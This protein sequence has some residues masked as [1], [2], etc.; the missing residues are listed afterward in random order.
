LEA[1]LEEEKKEKD[2]N[3]VVNHSTLAWQNPNFGR[4]SF[5]SPF[6]P[7]H[8]QP[9]IPTYTQPPPWQSQAFQAQNIECRP[10]AQHP[11]APPP[12]PYKGPTAPPAPT[13]LEGQNDPLPSVG[14]IIPILG[15]SALEFETKK[16]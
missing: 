12:P 15:G 2:M 1:I 8:F 5:A 6:P 9:P 11:I 13:K 16:D 4:N 10:I 14:T 3:S 7:P